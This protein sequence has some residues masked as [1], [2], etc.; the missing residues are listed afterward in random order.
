[1]KQLFLHIK[2]PTTDFLSEIYR[3][4]E[5]TVVRDGSLHYREVNEL[6]QAHDRVIMMGHGSPAGLFGN[7]EFFISHENVNALKG[8]ENIYIWCHASAFVQNYELKG[9][10]TGMFISE[11]S[12][13]LYCGIENHPKLKQEVNKSNKMFAKEIRKHILQSTESIHAHTTSSYSVLSETS[14]VA[15]YNGDRLILF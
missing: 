8:K 5:G 14:G 1:M 6:I 10:S 4:V 11:V 3:D 9:F 13:A 7:D 15:K 12:E 2:D